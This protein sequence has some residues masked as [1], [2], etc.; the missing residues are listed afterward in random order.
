MGEAWRIV[1]RKHAAA[2]FDGEGARLNGG[3]WNS[4]GVRAVY[5]SVTKSLAALETLV[6]L[7]LPVTSKYVAIPL[8]FHD[9]LVETFP[10]ATLPDGWDAEPP[11]LIS[12]QIGD[13][14]VK[15]AQSALLALPSVITGETNF[16]INPAHSDFAKIKIG[17]PEPFS[18]DPRLV[19]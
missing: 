12:Q 13:A 4:V 9:A 15:N 1:K 16:L 10:P 19:T 11:S 5:V 3:R 18:F 6:H 2:A 14:W 7:K 17:K 8:R